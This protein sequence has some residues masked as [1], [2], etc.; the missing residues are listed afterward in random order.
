MTSPAVQTV[1]VST[2]RREAS[3]HGAMFASTWNE[4]ASL[5]G[6]IPVVP[7]TLEWWPDYGSGPLAGPEGK[8]AS[9]HPWASTVICLLD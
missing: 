4:R 3:D 9:L 2:G 5:P 6:K 7:E 8:T 1:V